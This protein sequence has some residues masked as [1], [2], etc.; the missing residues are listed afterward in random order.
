MVRN[1]NISMRGTWCKYSKYELKERDDITF[2]VPTKNSKPSTYDVFD[3]KNEILK[4]LLYI[5]KIFWEEPSKNMQDQKAKEIFFSKRKDFQK[6]ALDFVNKYGFLGNADYLPENLDFYDD[7]NLGVKL[8]YHNVVPTLDFEKHYFG[9][10]DRDWSKTLDVNEMQYLS[11][12]NE[13]N[14]QIGEK[15]PEQFIFAKE[16]SESVYEILEFASQIYDKMFVISSYEKAETEDE[17][18]MF[19]DFI[20]YSVRHTGLSMY[21]DEDANKMVLN[22][23]LGTLAS[24]IETIFV[25][26]ETNNRN[27]VRLCRYCNKPFIAT[28]L[29]SFYDKPQCRNNASV[30]NYRKRKKEEDK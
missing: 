2:I 15:R 12:K 10:L 6:L 14:E 22:L 4:D 25:F 27:E 28:N 17:K 23:G 5:G 21:F 16:Y 30:R 7:E 20:Y 24:I 26:N 18:E 29:N 13:K 11:G 1:E 9:F 8:G 19:S 3:V